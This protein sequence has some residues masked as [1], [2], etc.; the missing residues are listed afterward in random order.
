MQKDNTL[1]QDFKT[2]AKAF[3][4]LEIEQKLSKSHIFQGIIH[5]PLI[6]F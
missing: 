2:I 5:H 3:D 6:S 1:E 4:N